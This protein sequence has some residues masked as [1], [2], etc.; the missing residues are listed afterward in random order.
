MAFIEITVESPAEVS[1]ALDSI[2]SIVKD[3][4]D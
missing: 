3:S 2:K 1:A 4:S